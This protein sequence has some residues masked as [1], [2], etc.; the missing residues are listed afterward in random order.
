MKSNILTSESFSRGST[1]YYL[2]YKRASNSSNYISLA[3]SQEQAGGFF[4]RRSVPVFEE[5]FEVF[6]GSFSSLFT[7]IGYY[8]QHYQSIQEMRALNLRG[9][10]NGIKGMEER[11]RPREKMLETGPSRMTDTELLAMLVGSGTPVESA[12]DLAHKILQS[13]DWRLKG[14]AALDFSGLCRFSGMG[15][16]KSSA[17]MAAMELARRIGR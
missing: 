14:L 7:S 17:I 15:I 1:H 3:L 10:L 13:V 12:I 11:E 6:I 9:E 2:D 5:D 4:F 8:G 16:A